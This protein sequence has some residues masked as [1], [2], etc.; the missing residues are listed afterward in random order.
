MRSF[1]TDQ[2]RPLIL[3]GHSFGGL[4]L[5]KA[6]ALDTSM[7][8]GA[9]ISQTLVDAHTER[10]RWPGIYDSTVGLIFL[11]TPFRGTH[12]SLSRGEIL[13]RAQELFTGSPAYVE[14]L[15]ILRA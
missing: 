4:I 8:H 3:I 9:D 12:D 1:Q 10:K 14:N 2:G 7:A 13:R 15:E 6:R 5:L 11:G